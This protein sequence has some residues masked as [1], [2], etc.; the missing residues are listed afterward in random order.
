MELVL[1]TGLLAVIGLWR[2]YISAP[3]TVDKRLF[4]GSV[5]DLWRKNYPDYEL[6]LSLLSPEQRA[7]Q[8]MRVEVSY[9]DIVDAIA[10]SMQAKKAWPFRFKQWSEYVF[11]KGVPYE[12]I[13]KQCHAPQLVVRAFMVYNDIVNFNTKQDTNKWILKGT[14]PD[15]VLEESEEIKEKYIGQDSLDDFIFLKRKDGLLVPADDILMG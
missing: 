2:K 13:A 7:E 12:A 6:N 5:I 8:F 11:S 3:A 4:T 10:I 14:V 9:G 1:I 15:Y